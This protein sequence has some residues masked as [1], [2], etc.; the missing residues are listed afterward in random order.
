MPETTSVATELQFSPNLKPGAVE[1]P[2]KRKGAS[3]TTESGTVAAEVHQERGSTSSHKT[4][5]TASCNHS[6]SQE[7][8]NLFLARTDLEEDVEIFLMKRMETPKKSL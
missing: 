3:G 7:A 1:R 6:S 5:D 8:R 2:N 4:V